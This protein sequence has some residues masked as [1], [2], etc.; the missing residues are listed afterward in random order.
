MINYNNIKIFNK[1]GNEIPLFYTSNLIFTTALDLLNV[2]DDDVVLYG[3]YDGYN[4]TEFLCNVIQPGKISAE[5]IQLSANDAKFYL[6]L[7]CFIDGQLIENAFPYIELTKETDIAKLY[8]TNY[9]T[10]FINNS[11]IANDENDA[12]YFYYTIKSLSDTVKCDLSNIDN[13]L[14][15]STVFVGKIEMERVSTG[16]VETETLIFGNAINNELT[17][18]SFNDGY[19]IK[20]ILDNDDEYIRFLTLNDD[21]EE[22]IKSNTYVLNSTSEKYVNVGFFPDKEGVYEQN[23]YVC[24]YDKTNDITTKIGELTVISEAIGEDER[25]RALFDN[26]GVLNPSTYYSVFKE[27]DLDEENIDW[28]LIN[29]K[30]KELFLT[31]DQIFPYVGTYKAL[32][33][34]VKFLGY[35]DIYFREWFKVI[36]KNEQFKDISY[37]IDLNGVFN[38]TDIYEDHSIKGY[39]KLNKLSMI[40]KINQESGKYD[41]YNLPI[42]ENVYDYSITEVLTKLIAL[43]QWLERNIIAVNCKILEISGEGVIYEKQ[44]Y[45][46]YGTIMQN[47]EHAEILEMDPKVEKRIVELIDGSANI[48]ISNIVSSVDNYIQIEDFKNSTI[49][50]FDNHETFEYPFINNTIV[51]GYVDTSNAVISDNLTKP[52]WINNNELY[53]LRNKDVSI[54]KIV[55]ENNKSILNS[56]NSVSDEAVGVV[57]GNFIDTTEFINAPI[58]Q[59]QR[60]YIRNDE[61]DW[62]NNIEFAILPSDDKCSYKV[63]DASGRTELSYDNIILYPM[64]NASLKYTYDNVYDV[65]MFKIKNYRFVLYN[66]KNNMY[67]NRTLSDDDFIINDEYIL[68]IQDGKILNTTDDNNKC[69]INFNYDFYNGGEQSVSVI[70]EYNAQHDYIPTIIDGKYYYNEYF[71]MNVNNIGHY[72][73]VA[74]SINDNGNVF[75]KEIENGCDVIINETDINIYSDQRIHTNDKDFY[76]KDSIGVLSNIND[77]LYE[78]PT[79]HSNNIPIF[80]DSYKLKELSFGKH[81]NEK[82]IQYPSISYAIDSA[83]D[84]DYIHLQNIVDK[85]NIHNIGNNKSIS[86]TLH[87]NKTFNKFPSTSTEIDDYVNIVVYNTLYNNAVFETEATLE[88]IS[89]NNDNVLTLDV[90]ISND[91]EYT[92]FIEYANDAINSDIYEYYIQPST[93][94]PINSAKILD[95]GDT[96]L[97]IDNKFNINTYDSSVIF[98]DGDCI[99]L[100]YSITKYK[101]INAFIRTDKINDINT[102][103]SNIYYYDAT[104]EMYKNSNGKLITIEYYENVDKYFS[105]DGDIAIQYSKLYTSDGDGDKQYNGYATYR[106]KE[107]TPDYIIIDNTFNYNVYTKFNVLGKYENKQDVPDDVLS[108][109]SGYYIIRSKNATGEFAPVIMNDYTKINYNNATYVLNP[110]ISSL[111]VSKAHQAYVNY[112]LIANHTDEFFNS[113]NRIYTDDNR[114][115]SYLDNSFSVIISKFD[116]NIARNLWNYN[117]IQPDKLYLHNEPITIDRTSR[118]KLNKNDIPQIVLSS[119]LK[120]QKDN[121]TYWKVYIRNND[122][123]RK[124]LFEVMNN[125]LVLDLKYHGIYDIEAY[126]YDQYGNLSI[127]SRDAY[128]QIK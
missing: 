91:I 30:S 90:K 64:E 56:L 55:D 111:N 28:Q 84:G 58:I 98:N 128:I 17:D 22:I 51:K 77:I 33:N 82:Y 103:D 39:K 86:F 114:L 93:L 80:R 85:F 3:Y 108:E 81:D 23:I 75:V 127:T 60:G 27:H 49:A 115:Y 36:N 126:N 13:L 61:Y 41:E 50:D 119:K 54:I 113:Y 121:Y 107:C 32:I 89:Y 38:D 29:Q 48:K 43:K 125:K 71:T 46:A 44:D 8:S 11:L 14:F 53:F 5:K 42:V 45:I 117:Y 79:A 116:N 10:S 34:A 106:V 70:Y 37:R 95:N 59:L 87:G 4:K 105:I 31:Y 97:S 123:S 118:L 12:N 26:F 67:T 72:N 25:Y 76:Y 6:P 47:I 63:I 2:S 78:Y 68:D 102:Y 94:Y 74:Y 73:I 112:T 69:I 66:N 99:K 92:K 19:E 57:S 21:T 24:L 122:N 9:N 96:K 120:D 7:K 124:L 15:P 62:M 83:K 104:S 88:S 65:P 101:D 20:L 40:Y 35:D 52:L 1:H 18:L 110:I 16:L 100:I 109:L